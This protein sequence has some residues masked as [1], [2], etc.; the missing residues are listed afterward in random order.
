M[1]RDPAGLLASPVSALST[2]IKTKEM[3]SFNKNK[4][5]RGRKY[6]FYMQALLKC[7]SFAKNAKGN[8]HF[9]LEQ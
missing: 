3:N 4:K 5:L 2:G 6:I 8:L 9:Q 7:Y 1:E